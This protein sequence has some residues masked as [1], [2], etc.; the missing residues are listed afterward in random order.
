MSPAEAWAYDGSLEGLVGLAARALRE[1]RAPALAVRRGGTESSSLF[2]FDE[3]G[4]GDRGKDRDEILSRDEYL[5]DLVIKAW[6]SEED[7]ETALLVLCADFGRLGPSVL[8]DHSRVETRRVKAACRRVTR[9]IHRLIGLAR[10]SPRS[11]GLFSAPLEPDHN[12]VA[13]LMPH[14]TRRFAGH[15]FAVVDLR[16]E[17][18]FSSR[19]GRIEASQGKEA[20]AL[21]PDRRGDEDTALW[22]R[23]YAAAENPARRN[24]SLRL[25][26]MPARYWKYL[27][28]LT[29]E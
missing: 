24:P 10:F 18:A 21:L 22:R 13:A 23:Y 15:D 11:D 16:R 27:P 29:R 19:G 25:R 28:E 1:G 4:I 26:L 8:G 9:E 5:L 14:F 7:I 3:A 17:L 20:L 6:M 12:V 2:A